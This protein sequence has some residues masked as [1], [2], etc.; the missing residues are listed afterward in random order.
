MSVAVLEPWVDVERLCEHFCMSRR[1]MEYRI[2]E[3]LP[4]KRFGSARRFQVSRCEDWLV[5]EG[6]VRDE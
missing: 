4:S 1:W 3:G 2:K 5:K 6:H